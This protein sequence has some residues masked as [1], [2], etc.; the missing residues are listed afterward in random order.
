VADPP[1][2][3]DLY[4]VAEGLPQPL[5]AYPGAQTALIRGEDSAG[6]L[7]QGDPALGAPLFGLSGG[8]QLLS[9]E[10]GF[11]VERYLKKKGYYSGEGFPKYAEKWNHDEVVKLTRGALARSTLSARGGRAFQ[12]GQRLPAAG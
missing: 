5:R 2:G 12:G 6:A 11:G 7:G 10:D 9:H 3:V 1:P 4:P 8:S